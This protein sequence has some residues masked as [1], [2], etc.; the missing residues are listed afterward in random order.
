MVTFFFRDFPSN[1]ALAKI[2]FP[3]VVEFITRIAFF[4]AHTHFSP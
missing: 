1:L 3:F 4:A 2:A